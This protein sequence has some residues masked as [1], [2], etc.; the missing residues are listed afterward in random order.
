MQFESAF[1]LALKS[2]LYPNC[3]SLFRSLHRL[4]RC[5][6]YFYILQLKYSLNF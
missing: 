4:M 5:L 2:G 6:E 1:Y 3:E